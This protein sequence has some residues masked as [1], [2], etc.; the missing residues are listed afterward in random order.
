MGA[1]GQVVDGFNGSPIDQVGP[2]QAY[3]EMINNF[4]IMLMMGGNA[5]SFQNALNNP[6]ALNK[7]GI[8]T[9]YYSNINGMISDAESIANSNR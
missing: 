3:G 2:F 9:S 6:S 4:I 5:S 1:V 8:F 7:I